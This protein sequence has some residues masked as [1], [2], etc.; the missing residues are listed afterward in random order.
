M[1]RYLS[2]PVIINEAGVIGGCSASEKGGP[3]FTVG[4]SW[5]GELLATH[6]FYGGI[7]LV[8]Y[9]LDEGLSSIQL[10]QV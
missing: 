7:S 10:S 2:W 1:R 8:E 6:G 4:E 3:Y 9:S 5:H